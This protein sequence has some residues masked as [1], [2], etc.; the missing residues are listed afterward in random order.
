MRITHQMLSRDYLKRMNTNLTQLTGSNEK[1]TS[2]RKFNK[3]HE[4]VTDAGKALRTRKL[5]TDNERYQ[6]AIRDATGRAAAAE[7]SLRTMNTLLIKVEDRV[8]EGLNGTM[9]ASDRE[10]IATEIEKVQEEM[11]QIMNS[12]FSGA[13][14]FG[15]AGNKDGSPPF[16]VAEDGG[17]VYNGTEVKDI[18][19]DPDTGLPSTFDGT[20]YTP[21]KYN[22]KNYVDI[23]FGYRQKDGKVDA[24]TGFLDT[25]S[26]VE[27][28]GYGYNDDGVPL[29]V[30][31]LLGDMVTNLNAN[32]TDGLG[33][34]L[35]AIAGTMDYMLSTITEIGAR[36]V[37]LEDTMASL[38]SEYLTLIEELNSLEGLDLSEEI[39]FNKDHEM[40]WMV[41]LQ[42]GSKIL[43][44][45][46]FDFIR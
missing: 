29:N 35:D 28:F 5:A 16:S 44:Q 8:V 12:Q 34:D 19:K 1:L 30:F 4:N 37:T 24:N 31:E 3:A 33:K 27:S 42:L 6:T 36:S 26:G 14:V 10:R 9:S 41:T 11:L 32:N 45:T 7:N 17:L 38:E 15:A 18:V 43:P 39:I 20:D 23:G 13:Y 40:S 22:A 2:G 46:I 25:Y 21:I